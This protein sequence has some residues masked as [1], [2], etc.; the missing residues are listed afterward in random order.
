MEK[1][2]EIIESKNAPQPIGPYS[3]AV[4]A[5]GMI[6]TS[7]Q[8]AINPESNQIADSVAEQTK[9]VLE[10]LQEVLTAGGSS[11][12]KVV[13]TTIYIKNMNDFAVINDVYAQYFVKNKPARSTVEVARLPKD[14][15]VEI[16]C[17]A[18]AE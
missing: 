15:L 13:K 7:G 16:D 9:Q 1:I 18:L 2:M 12:E 11:L 14:V 10:N 4:K 8:I 6:F 5:N 17:I 3:Q